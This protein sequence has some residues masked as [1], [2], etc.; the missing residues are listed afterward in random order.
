MKQIPGIKGRAEELGREER[1]LGKEDKRE[2]GLGPLKEP[3]SQRWGQEPLVKT[4]CHLDSEG[5]ILCKEKRR[6]IIVRREGSP[7]DCAV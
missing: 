3:R 1:D 2:R 6:F 5:L 7:T 4:G